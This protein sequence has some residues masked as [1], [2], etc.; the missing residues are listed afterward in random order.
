L[1]FAHLRKAAT[2]LRSDV[3]EDGLDALAMLLD[4]APSV[5]EAWIGH[6]EA[7]PESSGRAS[8]KFW[9]MVDCIFAG[10]FV[11]SVS[12]GAVLEDRRKFI[13]RLLACVDKSL[14]LAA[15]GAGT[16]QYDSG[17]PVD[18]DAAFHKSCRHFV[19][20]EASSSPA[21]VGSFGTLFQ[22]FVKLIKLFGSGSNGDAA[23]PQARASKGKASGQGLEDDASE[24]ESVS[25][26]FDK[27]SRCLSKLL[28]ITMATTSS[29]STFVD[30]VVVPSVDETMRNLERIFFSSSP[31]ATSQE[32]ECDFDEA[33]F[34]SK[35]SCFEL[36]IA[37]SHFVDMYGPAAPDCRQRLDW[38]GTFCALAQEELDRLVLVHR[39]FL[40]SRASAPAA[41]ARSEGKSEGQGHFVD[42]FAAFIKMLPV[43][44]SSWTTGEHHGDLAQKLLTLVK[45]AER[46]PVATEKGAKQADGH[47]SMES[48]PCAS[49][50]AFAV[51]KAVLASFLVPQDKNA[52]LFDNSAGAVEGAGGLVSWFSALSRM[53][54]EGFRAKDG[55]TCVLAAKAALRLVQNHYHHS[56]EDAPAS[57]RLGEHLQKLLL[58]LFAITVESKTG[59]G[60]KGTKKK[61]VF[62]PFATLKDAGK[63]KGNDD[64]KVAEEL[65]SLL[66]SLLH[67]LSPI[68]E[69]M[70]LGLIHCASK[71]L[72]VRT[73][74][75]FEMVLS[76]VG[77]AT[78]GFG[79]QGL[80]LSFL[81]SVTLS[82]IQQGSLSPRRDP[83]KADA[84]AALGLTQKRQRLKREVARS[85][86]SYFE[87]PTA[88]LLLVTRSVVSGTSPAHVCGAGGK[89]SEQTD[90][91]V[92]VLR[93]LLELAEE[94]LRLVF[95]QQPREVDRAEAEWR[96]ALASICAATLVCFADEDEASGSD[97]KVS[98]TVFR[99]MRMRSDASPALLNKLEQFVQAGTIHLLDDD[100]KLMVAQ[101]SEG[102]NKNKGE[103]AG[104]RGALVCSALFSLVK[105][106]AFSGGDDEANQSQSAFTS[107]VQAVE[108]TIPNIRD[109]KLLYIKDHRVCQASR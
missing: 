73:S 29:S 63:D 93:F 33:S 69:Q 39:K 25:A 107:C 11:D 79:N 96:T 4:R 66:I 97:A 95:E 14:A 56:G 51:R 81:S 9:A 85:L 78:T 84:S 62:G 108:E 26:I 44:L 46:F 99:L 5:C 19:A 100:S 65:R 72:G 101:D 24:L 21:N 71:L 37:A 27:A 89:T 67:Y 45:D 53:V 41:A 36:A 59:K 6:P 7:Q 60:G 88:A 104:R 91:P 38:F 49:G 40:Q 43:F 58:P 70:T 75:G 42:G 74:F 34:R 1:I 106:G 10:I 57:D 105:T 31:A 3:S 92:W 76:L 98:E 83:S 8:G 90:N 12:G 17:R 86:L 61:V 77:F 2:H 54:W 87:S 50:A 82:S 52:L 18:V 109:G 15:A 64:A 22:H 103:A 16:Q 35:L 47:A 23:G 94:T 30:E 32:A 20:E 80:H 68:S 55:E 13:A 28:R 48:N 102:E